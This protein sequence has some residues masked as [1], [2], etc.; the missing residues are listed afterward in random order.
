MKQKVLFA[1]CFLVLA[2]SV[3]AEQPW[4][5]L[6]DVE[7]ERGV[8]SYYALLTEKPYI[9]DNRTQTRNWILQDAKEHSGGNAS[10]VRYIEF[11][12]NEM[13]IQILNSQFHAEGMGKGKSIDFALETLNEWEYPR[14]GVPFHHMLDLF[15]TAMQTATPAN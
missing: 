15:C 12:C 1:V 9:R 13:R 2:T 4:L 7:D 5:H 8:T 11:D 3:K 6:A 14:P 10:V